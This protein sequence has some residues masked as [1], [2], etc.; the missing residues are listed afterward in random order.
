LDGCRS[1]T[2]DFGGWDEEKGVASDG[3]RARGRIPKTN[4]HMV[5]G[6]VRFLFHRPTAF[7]A[8]NSGGKGRK[9][10]GVYDT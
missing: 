10:L 6:A 3:D 9:G 1:P 7:I 4:T 5:I 2:R 8:T